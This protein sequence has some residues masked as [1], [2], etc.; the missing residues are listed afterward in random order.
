[1]AFNAKTYHANKARKQAWAYLA[2][3]REIAGRVGRG[4]AYDWEMPRLSHFAKLARITMRMVL[5]LRSD[6]A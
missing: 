2:Q 5:A 3:A 1:M 4:E 6:R